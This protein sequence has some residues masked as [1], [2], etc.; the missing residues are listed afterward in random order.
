MVEINLQPLAFLE[1]PLVPTANLIVTGAPGVQVLSDGCLD[2]CEDKLGVEMKRFR[3]HGARTLI[4]LV[5]DEE[6]DPVDFRDIMDAARHESIEVLR[7]PIRDFSVPKPDQQPDWEHIR[8]SAIHDLQN[9]FS[10]AIHC[11]AGIGRSYMMAGS[12]LVHLGQKPEEVFA[13]IRAIQPD[14]L[15]T[16]KQVAYLWS[17]KT[18]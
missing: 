2:L 16:S 10:V 18:L 11:L 1:T 14:A 6:L 5:E 15:E 8:A 12:L 7:L 17:Q 3:T 13:R 4:A 9:G